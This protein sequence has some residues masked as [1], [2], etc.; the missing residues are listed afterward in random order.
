[1]TGK[2]KSAVWYR[3][4]NAAKIY[5]AINNAHWSSN[6][7]ISVTLKEPVGRELYRSI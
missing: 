1:M 5:P 4:D 7:R 2:G 3:L 6:F